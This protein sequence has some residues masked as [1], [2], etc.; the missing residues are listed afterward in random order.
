MHGRVASYACDQPCGTMAQALDDS[1]G[2]R[3]SCARIGVILYI[4]ALLSI[5][6]K[7]SFSQLQSLHVPNDTQDLNNSQILL[8]SLF[9][10]LY[11][12][13]TC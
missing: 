2:W 12:S 6:A 13:S 10:I 7:I 5:S 11:L 3:L 4:T 1:Q 9:V 8:Y